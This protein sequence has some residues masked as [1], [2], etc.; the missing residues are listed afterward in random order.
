VISE[1]GRRIKA[2]KP[3]AVCEGVEVLRTNLLE[4]SAVKSIGSCFRYRVVD[5]AAGPSELGAE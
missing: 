3:V 4:G 2:A 5:A 1:H